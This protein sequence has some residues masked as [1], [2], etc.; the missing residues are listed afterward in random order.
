[1]NIAA[2]AGPKAEQ[3]PR[4]HGPI[5]RV[6]V[7]DGVI[8][9]ALVGCGA[10]V[11]IATI[12]I[13]LFL[14]RAGV[15]GI[16]AVGIS[17]LISGVLWK[18][19]ADLFGGLPLIVGTFVSAIGAVIVGA[20]P[21]MFAAVWANE[22]ASK[23]LCPLYRRT[24][25]VAAAIPSVVYGWL[26]LVYLV[27][28]ME[29]LA[30]VIR[31]NQTTSGE[32]LAAASLLLGI[33]IAPTVLLLSLDS[34]SRVPSALR[35]ASAALGGSPWQTAMRVCL[36]HSWRGIVIALFFGFARAAGETMAV[37]MVIGGARKLPG[38][39]FSPTTTISTQIVMDMQN[40]M[41]NTTGS[42]VLFSMSLVL[43]VV[44]VVVVLFTRG[45]TRQGRQGRS[46]RPA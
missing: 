25:E 42:N 10:F 14:G 24:M 37:Q 38:D 43:L 46:R 41:P 19:E 30:H 39:L 35:D 15:R 12:A 31:P 32:G 29:S 2:T 18:P 7:L 34:L 22:F 36:P 17:Q 3:E 26:A 21:A 8:R 27:P 9:V 40:A 1:M 5:T 45:L 16:Q 44:S 13:L 11:L 4:E 23:A 6:R 33:M 28:A 20:I